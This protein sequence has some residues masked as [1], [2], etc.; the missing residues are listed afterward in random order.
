MSATIYRTKNYLC[1]LDTNNC[2]LSHAKAQSFAKGCVVSVR[3]FTHRICGTHKSFSTNSHDPLV[4]CCVTN[5]HE[6]T[7]LC[8]VGKSFFL[9]LD[10]DKNKR[11]LCYCFTLQ[12]RRE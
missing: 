4:F 6:F 7:R 1:L 8:R 5:V 12:I 9:V 11:A 2:F 10:F 3:M